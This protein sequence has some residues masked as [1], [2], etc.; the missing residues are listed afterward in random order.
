MVRS[1][2]WGP[3]SF[4]QLGNSV[5]LQLV[6]EKVATSATWRSVAAGYNHNVAIRQDGTLWA[7]GFNSN[8]QLGT[9]TLADQAV[10]VQIGT[11]TTWRSVAA[12]YSHTLAL[13]QDGTLWAWG[14]NLFGQLGIGTVDDQ[15][16]P[17]QVGTATTWR[18]IVAGYGHT[19]ALAPGWYP[20]GLGAQ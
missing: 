2:T 10:P 9:G 8:G 14:Y 19:L 17:V 11:A 4:G 12:G 13:R 16:T 3:T 5:G 15:L 6:P 1:A 20:L 7:W 18:S